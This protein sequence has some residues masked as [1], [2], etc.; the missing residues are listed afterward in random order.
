MKS[1]VR[2]AD[3]ERSGAMRVG[4]LNAN[5]PAADTDRNHHADGLLVK[6]VQGLLRGR[7]RL[8]HRA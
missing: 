6:P 7:H 5:T 1:Q 8:P 4:E 3:R 2:G